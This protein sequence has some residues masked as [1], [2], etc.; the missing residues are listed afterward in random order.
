MIAREKA[1][2]T[3]SILLRQ[4]AMHNT[5]HTTTASNAIS[6]TISTS[7]QQ[8]DEDPTLVQ[9]LRIVDVIG[10]QIRNGQLYI[11]VTQLPG[12]AS[13]EDEPPRNSRGGHVETF[14]EVSLI[15]YQDAYMSLVSNIIVC[16]YHCQQTETPPP[17]RGC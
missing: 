11:D 8:P 12:I 6:A 3:R 15:S 9:T 4:Q 5:A 7:T 17:A 14:P 2:L 13:V 1:R 10:S 16:F